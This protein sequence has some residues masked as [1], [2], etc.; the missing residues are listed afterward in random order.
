MS[1][2]FS[3][4]QKELKSLSSYNTTIEYSDRFA[5]MLKFLNPSTSLPS[6]KVTH[7]SR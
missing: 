5:L 1:I 7:N 4:H 3:S 2:F 6:M